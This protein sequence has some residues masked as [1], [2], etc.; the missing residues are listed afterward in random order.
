[1][2]K[3]WQPL[4]AFFKWRICLIYSSRIV[5]SR[6]C[7]SKGTII[8]KIKKRLLTTTSN[9]IKEGGKNLEEK[10]IP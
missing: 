8:I 6:S 9:Y 2:I 4:R 3:L 7:Q 10:L 1:M 5:S